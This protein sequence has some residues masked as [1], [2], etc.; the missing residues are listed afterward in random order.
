MRSTIFG[1]AAV[2][3]L[4]LALPAAAQINPFRGT[5]APPMSRAD[6]DQMN[7]AT[8]RL[9]ERNPVMVGNSESWK[10]QTSGT[11]RVERIFR[12][13]NTECHALSYLLIRTTNPKSRKYHMNWCKTPQGWKTA[14]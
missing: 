13:H 3:S 14:A 7:G 1:L 8:Q 2:I 6:L 9:N 10:G 12:A 11:V 5:N 4:S